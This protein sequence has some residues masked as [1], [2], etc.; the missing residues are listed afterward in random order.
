MSQ[1][2]YYLASL[3][4]D[5]E[6]YVLKHTAYSLKSFIKT[7]LK[8]GNSVLFN[9]IYNAFTVYRPITNNKWVLPSIE[10]LR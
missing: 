4:E 7:V 6:D 5:G 9:T 10:E 8:P 1:Q 3:K 2:P